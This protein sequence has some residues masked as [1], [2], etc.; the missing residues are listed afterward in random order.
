MWLCAQ[1]RRYGDLTIIAV[2]DQH[3]S[4]HWFGGSV[5]VCG[6]KTLRVVILQRGGFAEAFDA[7]G[8]PFP[9]HRVLNRCVSLRNILDVSANSEQTASLTRD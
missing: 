8:R 6:Y 4:A 9:L 5:T 2:F 3:V 7:T 1:P